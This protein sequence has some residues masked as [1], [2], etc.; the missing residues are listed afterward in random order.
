MQ[1]IVFKRKYS[2]LFDAVKTEN[3]QYLEENIQ[4][5]KKIVIE[6]IEEKNRLKYEF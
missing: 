4:P 2:V 1:Q 3:V 5:I 6:K